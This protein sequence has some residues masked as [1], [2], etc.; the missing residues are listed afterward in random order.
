MLFEVL[1]VLKL[2]FKLS[3]QKAKLMRQSVENYRVRKREWHL[4]F[5]NLEKAYDKIP[6]EVFWW[7]MTKKGIPKNYINIVQHIYRKVTANV[8]TVEGQQWIF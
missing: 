2:I 8:R 1:Y 7:G 6:R 5:T 3:S 4:T